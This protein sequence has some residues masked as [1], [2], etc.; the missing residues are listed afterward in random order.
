MLSA[1][2]LQ[3]KD[4][5]YATVDVELGPSF[6]KE[7]KKKDCVYLEDLVKHVLEIKSQ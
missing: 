7:N 5:T 3:N 4:S 2:Q 6:L 1:K